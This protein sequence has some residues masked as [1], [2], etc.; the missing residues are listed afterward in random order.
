MSLPETSAVV[1]HD[2][3]Q[4]LELFSASEKPAGRWRIG[5]ESE[6]FGVSRATAAPLQYDGD[7][8]VLRIFDWL[9]QHRGYQ[10]ESE[11]PGGPVI[12]VRKGG[13]SLTLEPGA[14]FE[15]SAPA[16]E[17]AHQVEALLVEHFQEI[18]PISAELDVAWL[19]IGFQPFVAQDQLPWVP[20][21]R[22]AI[23]REYLPK[24]GSGAWDM[25]RRTATVQG[26]FDYSDPSDAMR[27]LLLCLRIAPLL[28]AWLANS[29]YVEGRYA[30]QL[31]ARGDVWLRMDPAR[32]GLIHG[33]W[34]RSEP[35]YEDYV[36]WAL[37]APMFLIKRGGRIIDNSGQPFR[38][39]MTHGFQGERATLQDWTL[40]VNSLF[41]EARLKSTLEVRSIDSL[42]PLMACAAMALVTG[43]L[44]DGL[45]LDD[46]TRLVSGISP[47]QAEQDRP[48]LIKRGLG[49]R[50]GG[51]EGFELAREV[52]SVA[53]EGLKRRAR[54][55]QGGDE[56]RWL[57]P[58]EQLLEERTS[59]AQR[60]LAELGT[61]PDP[62]RLVAACCQERG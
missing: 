48:D 38:D 6:K 16:V 14:Q 42:R 3:E 43:L 8:G 17:D 53:R 7:F 41:P 20:K 49:A 61:R 25:M 56:R 58:L 29:P 32:S 11:L 33:L 19:C 18:A 23:M 34:Q 52:L 62:A 4:L 36:E 45:A 40:H 37:E 2:K 47:T 24:R 21:Q 30:G 9:V 59:P 22:Y 35:G 10:P 1:L 31:S 55:H 5:V 46:A 44:Y 12:A 39:F 26:N 60:L 15:L 50:Y 51:R 13:V 27:K 54:L 28:N 57:E